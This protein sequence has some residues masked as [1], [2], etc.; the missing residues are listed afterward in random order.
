MDLRISRWDKRI[1][2]WHFPVILLF[3]LIIF[4]LLKISG[5]S[6]GVYDNIFNPNDKNTNLLNKSRQ[7]R[8][9]EWLVNTQLTISQANT[10]FK[11]INSSYG[12][13]E[14]MT[15]IADV[16]AKDWS[17]AF[18]PQNWSFFIL[19]LEKAFAFKW[20]FMGFMLIISTYYLS[21]LF[22]KDRKIFAILL[23]LTIF[24]SPFIQWWY[25]Y[26][27][28]ASVYY[29]FF[30]I[31]A[32]YHLM[33]T[34]NYKH[35]LA[36]SAGLAYLIASFA[37]I[38]YPPFQIATSIAILVMA[39]AY[40]IKYFKEE[41]IKKVL[42]NLIWPFA[43]LVIGLIIVII[44][45]K[46]RA[47][48][49]DLILNTSYPGHRK[50]GSGG[51]P[52]L[53][54]FSNHLQY[55]LQST[56]RALNY[57]YPAFKTAN[58]SEASNF[59]LLYPYLLAPS[60][61]LIYKQKKKKIKLDISFLLT[62]IILV[63]LTAFLFVKFLTPIYEIA[64]GKVP[65]GRL[66]IG[67]GVL[68]ILQIVLFAQNLKAYNEKTKQALFT[69]SQLII[70]T[71]IILLTLGSISFL[72]SQESQNFVRLREVAI[73]VLI[74]T[75][76]IYLFLK[77]KFEFAIGLVLIFSII[78]TILI[79]PVRMGLSP[80]T[81]NQLLLDISKIKNTDPNSKWASDNL[82]IE[83][84]PQTIGAH[85]LSGV[86]L[87][88]Q[89]NLWQNLDKSESKDTYNRYAHVVFNFYNP[90]NSKKHTDIKLAGGDNFIV[91]INPCDDDMKQLKI[92]YII[93]QKNF[94]NNCLIK[95]S[96]PNPNNAGFIIYKI[97]N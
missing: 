18:K 64:L 49:I 14:D 30:I 60:F 73:C 78:S 10:G 42:Q 75:A 65:L 34:D 47:N 17:L 2:T 36:L 16:P 5:S 67:I 43:S 22:F 4:T 28:L 31:I 95:M 87:Y 94:E 81:K 58:Q 72:T 77:S 40:L 80:I 88:P 84:L 55:A 41:K 9:D 24:F 21:L 26:I 68:G 32:F 29:A 6:I 19:D 69:K 12:N 83:N 38:L 11:H 91:N 44:F 27:T 46:T 74:V 92:T 39:S 7:I 86:Y 33:K 53:H 93:S 56:T 13:G 25:Q 63:L 66:L 51:F 57:S 45:I 1:K 20:W 61:Y 48:V 23:S 85:S 79:H 37:L 70:Y 96:Q 76:S 82:F 90:T 8:S 97:I 89:N 50:V 52:A 15:V 3:I 59:I 54:F 71:S 35:K 62:N